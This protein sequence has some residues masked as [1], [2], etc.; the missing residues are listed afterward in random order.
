MKRIYLSLGSNIGNRAAHLQTAVSA[1]SGWLAALRCS[2]VYESRALLPDG[3]PS[4]W[5]KP[6]YNMVVAGETDL[7]PEAVLSRTQTIERQSGRTPMGYWAPRELD[8]DIVWMEG[9]AMH[10]KE[11]TIPHAH[12][13]LRDFVLVPWAEL[14]GDEIYPIGVYSGKTMKEIITDQAMG[15][16]SSLKRLN[17]KI[18]P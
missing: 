13:T 15:E 2:S 1:L 5:A 7:S 17:V 11:L 8:I 10:S 14:A 18:S 9:I 16:G 3:A 4:D 6:Y 12:A